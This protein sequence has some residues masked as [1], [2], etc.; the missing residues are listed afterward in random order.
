MK[1]II[2]NIQKF[3]TNDGPG[4]RTNVFLK[5]CPLKCIWCHNPESQTFRPEL[6]FYADK[7]VG[8]G[9]CLAVCPNECHKFSAQGAHTIDRSVCGACFACTE[10]YCG[11]L[12][13]AGREA[14]VEEVLEEVLKDKIFYENS[15]GGMTLSGG[16]PLAQ[17]EFSLELLKRAKAEGLHTAIETC[18]FVSAEKMEEIVQY[19]D[20]FLFDYKETD[21]ELH[22]RFT[23]ADNRLI[24]Q[25]LELLNRIGK[26]IILRCPLIP[27]CNDRTEHFLG[28][29]ETANRLE[30]VLHVELEPYHPLGEGKVASLGREKHQFP[31]PEKEQK[32][33]W[34]QAIQKDCKKEVKFA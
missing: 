12:E 27:G 15:S 17:F 9:R 8:C 1:G 14:S 2:F 22:T 18:G 28:I 20:L 26:E 34:L 33:A 4:I 3:C 32:E 30:Y 10:L 25:N 21:P 23:G 16:E 31:S 24:L 13:S 11:A 29:A 6:M 19:T 5:G 7:C